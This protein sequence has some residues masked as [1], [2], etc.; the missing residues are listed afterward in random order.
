MRG[1]FTM[2]LNLLFLVI[3]TLNQKVYGWGFNGHQLVADIAEHLISDSTRKSLEDLIPGSS[4][5]DIS[6]WADKIKRTPKYRFTSSL[7]YVNP[8]DDE[9]RVCSF[10]MKR[11]CKHET[12]CLIGA[13][14]NYTYRLDSQNGLPNEDR[15]EALKFITHFIGDLHQPLHVSG[16]QRGGNQAKVE[17]FGKKTNL[18]S[19]WDS[20]ILNK[21]ISD[22]FNHDDREYLRYLIANLDDEWK[23]ER[24]DWVSEDS[25]LSFDR[26]KDDSLRA[27]QV[28]QVESSLIEQVLKY[29]G[30]TKKRG[31]NPPS[32]TPIAAD[33]R[34]CVTTW[35]TEVNQLN[36][37]LVWSEYEDE[38]GKKNENQVSVEYYN[39][40]TKV[41][42]RMIATAGV[43]LA[44]M[45]DELVG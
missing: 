39:E 45:L 25:C 27:L 38:E 30:I 17:F 11:D 36:C 2:S 5:S 8:E 22:D 37:D 15:Q 26:S 4:L 7:H 14:Y 3:L 12:K 41:V 35:A 20:L 34:F 6:T 44:F 21:R 16:R 10:D 23:N 9:P 33:K 40:S 43:R 28:Q 32:G 18:H 24:E 42:D 29:F 13:I 19:M 1:G 31:K